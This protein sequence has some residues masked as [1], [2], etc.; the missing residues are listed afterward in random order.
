ME[1]DRREKRERIGLVPFRSLILW[2][3]CSLPAA[4]LHSGTAAAQEDPFE[5]SPPTFSLPPQCANIDPMT[6]AAS[7]VVAGEERLALRPLAAS[8]LLARLDLLEKE[9]ELR[10]DYWRSL[11]AIRTEAARERL[12]LCKD[13]SD[14]REAIAVEAAINADDAA[15]FWKWAALGAGV[16]GVAAGAGAVLYLTH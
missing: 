10:A 2:L 9:A 12:D 5:P 15:T 3:A 4:L 8:C 6:D 11:L 14:R 1:L 7:V 13:E 16:V